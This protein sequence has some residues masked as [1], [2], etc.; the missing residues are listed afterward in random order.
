[1]QFNAVI[2]T[3]QLQSTLTREETV[4]FPF[5]LH[6]RVERLTSTREFDSWIPN[7]NYPFPPCIGEDDTRVKIPNTTQSC[8]W[9]RIS[10]MFAYNT[11]H[12]LPNEI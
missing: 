4:R 11:I 1:M 6:H 2:K 7:C 9:S 3:D 10:E 8:P 12:S 5:L